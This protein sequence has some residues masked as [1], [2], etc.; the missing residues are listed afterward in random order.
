MLAKLVSLHYTETPLN[1]I[2][3]KLLADSGIEI[4]IDAKALDGVGV[5]SDTPVTI[6]VE[7]ISLAAALRHLLRNLDLTYMIRDE[8]LQITTP[9]IADYAS[10]TA[11]TGWSPLSTAD[12]GRRVKRSGWKRSSSR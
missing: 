9:E 10:C 2:V 4:Q 11:G 6:H 8:V 12:A 3:E 5:S 7:N 1:Q